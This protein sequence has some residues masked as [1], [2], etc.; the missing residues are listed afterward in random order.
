MDPIWIS[1]YFSWIKD[2]MNASKG[3]IFQSGVIK[4]R[5]WKVDTKTEK[6]R[7]K[8]AQNGEHQLL[9]LL[10]NSTLFA[11]HYQSLEFGE[12]LLD[13]FE[14]IGFKRNQIILQNVAF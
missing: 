12:K 2:S 10:V 3:G 9:I 14:T 4:L 6:F 7:V 11:L 1:F 13:G 8:L 5:E